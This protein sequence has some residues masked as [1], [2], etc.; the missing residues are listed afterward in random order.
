[1]SDV[2]KAFL[3]ATA[4]DVWLPVE[5]V[6]A[7]LGESTE[8]VLELAARTLDAKGWPLVAAIEELDPETGQWRFVLKQE[9]CFSA[10]D[11]A[12]AVAYHRAKVS[13]HEAIVEEFI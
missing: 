6:A 2:R 10:E 12:R 1:M 4:G 8:T 11:Y 9:A 5:E 13:G 7:R 3:A